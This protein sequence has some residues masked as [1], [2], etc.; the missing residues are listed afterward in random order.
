[1]Y[2][3]LYSAKQNNQ[4]PGHYFQYK[5][6]TPNTWPNSCT[7]EWLRIGSSVGNDCILG[8]TIISPCN[9]HP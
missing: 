7:I 1:L 5:S 2:I 6:G 8:E 9:K 4:L 3:D